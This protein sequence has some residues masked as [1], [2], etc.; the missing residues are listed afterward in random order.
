MPAIVDQPH[1]VSAPFA[2]P[3]ADANDNE[4]PASGVLVLVVWIGCLAISLAGVVLPYGRP[5]APARPEPPLKAEILQVELTTDPLP[6]IQPKTDAA[7]MQPPAPAQAPSVPELPAMTAVAEPNAV[8][9]ALPVEGPVAIVEPAKASFAAAPVVKEVAPSTPAVRTLTYGQGEGRQPAPEYPLRARREGQEGAVGIRF[10]VGDDGRVLAAE[11]NA[12]C[13]WK[14]LNDA[15][16][17]V[18]RERWR[19]AQG[20]IRLYEVSIRFQLTN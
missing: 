5:V 20:G 12:P 14:L 6:A 17:R 18:V 1:Q 3:V 10:S 8:A 2:R 9:F 7:P 4:L 11:I 13:P 16:L 15:A 19:F